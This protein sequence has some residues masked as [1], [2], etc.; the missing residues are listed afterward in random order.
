MQSRTFTAQK[1]QLHVKPQ[2]SLLQA[3]HSAEGTS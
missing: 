1:V 2:C 3:V